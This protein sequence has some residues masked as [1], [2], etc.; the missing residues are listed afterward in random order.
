VLYVGGTKKSQQADIAQALA[1][2]QEYERQ[3]QAV[4]EAQI[5]PES[6]D[7]NQKRRQRR[8]K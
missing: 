7:P 8:K 6:D 4:R 3:K 1:L 5:E 2:H